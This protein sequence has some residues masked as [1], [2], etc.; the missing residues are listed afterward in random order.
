[1]TSNHPSNIPGMLGAAG[2]SPT[3]QQMYANGPGS[4]N[5]Q[6]S[7]PATPVFTPSSSQNGLTPP[8][9]S[10]RVPSKMQLPSLSMNGGQPY[11]G[12]MKESDMGNGSGRVT[13][14][15]FANAPAN[16]PLSGSPAPPG[17]LLPQQMRAVSG[18]NFGPYPV[19]G[20]Y[21]PP[22]T[23]PSPNPLIMPSNVPIPQA[24]GRGRGSTVGTSRQKKPKTPKSA[25]N[26]SPNAAMPGM[27]AAATRGRGSRASRGAAAT[28]RGGP[29]GPMPNGM[30]NG[31]TGIMMDAAP[32]YDSWAMMPRGA[33]APPMHRGGMMFQHR[34]PQ[35]A[36]FAPD[37]M[38]MAPNDS[39]SISTCDSQMGYPGPQR[40]PAQPTP[41]TGYVNVPSATIMHHPQ[42][43]AP[44]PQSMHSAPPTLHEEPPPAPSPFDRIVSPVLNGHTWGPQQIVLDE[45]LEQPIPRGTVVRSFEFELS[46]MHL[47]TIVGR[48]DLEFVIS[49]HL[50][51]EPFQL[52]YWP[53][54]FVLLRFNEHNLQ[55]DRSMVHVKP[56]HRVACVKHLCR[57]GK[58]FLE[59]AVVGLGEDPHAPNVLSRRKT[60]AS[61][62][63]VCTTHKNT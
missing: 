56:A 37:H 22:S 51:Y 19:N 58:N 54:E 16:F 41:P 45:L 7:G 10:Q 35:M 15:A 47:Q 43:Q 11:N 9:Q 49:A 30:F 59:I 46:P 23:Q 38:Q 33:P 57:P 32:P 27:G 6:H 31:P 12:F 14:K 53:P 28:G 3:P 1:M 29:A 2:P 48:S 24:S 50:H 25:A 40:G 13:P 42:P 17:K 21:L 62:L 55:L 36:N 8:Q 26:Q 63:K 44:L 52:C 18:A 61:T 5:G 60:I 20:A 39:Y 34:A 4:A